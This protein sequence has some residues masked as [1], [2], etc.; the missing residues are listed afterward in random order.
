MLDAGP[1][2]LGKVGMDDAGKKSGG[3]L[4]LS[5]VGEHGAV[6]CLS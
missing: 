2:A 6:D 5:H 4:E 3:F 1:K